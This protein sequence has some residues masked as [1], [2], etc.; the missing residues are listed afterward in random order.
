MNRHPPV[1]VAAVEA[2]A[3][4]NH[5]LGGID[6]RFRTMAD[7]A[8]VLLWMTGTDGMCDFFN[9]TWLRFTGRSMA[10]EV[11]LG[12]AEGV[13]PEDF[14]HCVN[15]F[16]A[17]FVKREPFSMEYRLR[18][19]DGEYRWILDRGAP[20]LDE[21][22][23][24]CG[25]IGSCVDITEQR[26]AHNALQLLNSELGRQVRERT[27]LAKARKELLREVHHR[28]KNDLQLVSSILRM[29]GRGNVN[30]NSAEVLKQ[31]EQRIHSIARVHEYMYQ[32]DD[33]ARLN[34][35]S[36]LDDILD[37]LTSMAPTR[38]R[39]ER[40]IAPDL[41][42][43]VDKAIPISMVLHELLTNA[44]RH[45]FPDRQ[46]TI[47]ITCKPI[48][49]GARLMLAV[50]DDGIGLNGALERAPRG[51]LGWTLIRALTA[52]VAGELHVSSD[53]GTHVTLC[54]DKT[55][56]EEEGGTSP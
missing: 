44:T 24:F 27:A 9:Q 32:S 10:D 11:G 48:E 18:R 28:V 16:M 41:T 6:S 34:F 2:F 30:E 37:E 33:M 47:R 53:G 19:H 23:R 31:C 22:A 49:N 38:V 36:H 54:V 55:P 12:W 52:Q 29:H 46:G 39:V 5:E 7:H 3:E 1:Q 50:D 42:L 56:N 26:D 20:H 43:K 8:P 17:A 15:T 45:A 21:T 35:S 4:Q 51:T 14:Q 25:F 40:D 13:H